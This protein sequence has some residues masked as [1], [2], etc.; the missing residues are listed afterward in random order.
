MTLTVQD[1]QA[2]RQKT[3]AGMMDCKRT[4]TQAN[5]NF[6]AAE[7]Y[8]R[9]KGLFAVA[10]KAERVSADG[11]VYA[12]T[13]DG[14]AVLLEINSETDFAAKNG[15]FVAFVE[16]VARVIADKQPADVQA[17]LGCV[18]PGRTGTIEEALSGM[19]LVFGENIRIRRFEVLTGGTLVT[20]MHLNW[21][22]RSRSSTKCVYGVE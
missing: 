13:L 18:Y 12:A 10:K 7:S 19:V 6:E 20:Y 2:L 4:L 22:S 9:E 14:K 8:L 11:I 21:Q 15:D 3:G 16:N 1:I 17:L 5:G